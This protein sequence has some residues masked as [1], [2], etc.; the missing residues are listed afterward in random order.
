MH[1]L[2][3]DIGTTGCKA[4][5][6]DEEGQVLGEGFREYS[7]EMDKSGKAEQ[8]SDIVWDLVKTVIAQAVSMT[9]SAKE[10]GAMS[11]SVQGDAIIPVDQNF[12]PVHSA[13]LGMDYRSQPQAEQC[14]AEFGDRELFNLTGMR[15]H[16]MNSLTKLLFFQKKYPKKF[17]KTKRITTYA[18]YILGKLGA[19]PVIDYTMASRTMAFDLKKREWSSAILNKLGVDRE[20]FSEA[21][22]SGTVVGTINKNLADELGL[23]GSVVLVTGG[24]DQPCNALGSGIVEPGQGIV[25][26]GTAEV[27]STVFSEINTSD[28]MY[29]GYYPCYIGILPDQYF[30]F[31]LNHVGG[32]LLSWFRDNFSGEDILA[33]K[34]KGFSVYRYLDSRMPED[35]TDL[36]VLP[37]FNGS[38]TPWSD[39]NSKGAI[40]GLTLNTTRFDIVKAI[41]ESLAFE[42]AINIDKMKSAGIGVDKIT[43]AG[44][45][46]RSPEWLQI[47]ADILNR[48]IQTT[49]VEE[50]GCL[51]AAIIAGKGAEMFSSFTEGVGKTVKIKNTYYP[52]AKNTEIYADKQE[53]Y[54]KLYPALK[55]INKELV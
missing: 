53:I 43:A 21:I 6:F 17:K 40:V 51:G 1:L 29:E 8:N 39:M 37:H 26:T 30:T 10:I 7:I 5:V 20:L 46:A 24:H 48:P 3:L 44:G 12:N 34:G 14:S 16:P 50:A 13:I 41:L 31:S 4:V 25:T 47:K 28:A 27:F 38:G 15:P 32:L 22:P 19:P 11:L 54:S 42:L 23:S 55:E 52:D 45:G 36:L 18:D 35:P 49:E 33:A 2:G 9:E